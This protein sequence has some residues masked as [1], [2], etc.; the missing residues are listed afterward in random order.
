[1]FPT[2]YLPLSKLKD[3]ASPDVQKEGSPDLQGTSKTS[4][5]NPELAIPQEVID[6]LKERHFVRGP[7]QESGKSGG[8]QSQRAPD[9]MIVDAIGRI[10]PAPSSLQPPAPGRF[11][12]IPDAFGWGVSATRYE[13]LPCG[14]L[15]QALQTQAAS[16][17]RIRFNVAGLVT[18]FKGKNYLLLQRAVR[19]YGHGNFVN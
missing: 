2:Y 17:E 16:P 6:K 11:V 12:F 10:V 4:E 9:R 3:A 19:A 14:M 15:E 5:G 13:L 18:E 7:Q 1:L 8:S